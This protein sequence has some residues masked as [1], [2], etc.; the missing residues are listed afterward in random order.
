MNN[1]EALALGIKQL[2]TGYNA[3]PEDFIRPGIT[4]AP[5]ALDPGRRVYSGKIPFFELAAVGH[6]AVIMTDI[7]LLP[8][9]R[10]LRSCAP[11]GGP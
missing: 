11:A 1:K 7:P 8:A 4:F 9:S 2:S 10:G 3:R 6:A 5:P